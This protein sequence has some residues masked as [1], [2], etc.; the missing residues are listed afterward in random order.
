M[1]RRSL[2]HLQPLPAGDEHRHLGTVFGLEKHLLELVFAGVKGNLRLEKT[3][4]LPVTVSS[5]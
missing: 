2:R 4:N 1:S 5:L 3:S